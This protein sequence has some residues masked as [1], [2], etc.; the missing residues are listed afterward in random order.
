MRA[1]KRKYEEH[2]K[3][4]LMRRRDFLITR[5]GK[6][7]DVIQ[8]SARREQI[9]R[10]AQE[11]GGAA[12]RYLMTLLLVGGVITVVALAP[13]IFGAM[14][15]IARRKGFFGRKG[16]F[17]AK[18]YLRKRKYITV[19]KHDDAYEIKL[20]REGA[21]IVLQKSLNDMR[22]QP[23][24]AW[25]GIWHLVMFDIPNKH[26]WARDALR[27]RLQAMGLYRM[28]ESVFVSPYPCKEEVLFL[29]DLLSVHQYVRLVATKEIFGDT[30]L[31]DYFALG[32]RK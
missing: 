5:M 18:N 29:T 3:K 20:T 1:S 12:T 23:T 24:G 10:K 6:E 26:K 21:D 7:W 31:C 30:D 22:I 13:N 11:A 16:F 17:D 2:L 19:R 32:V 28:Q 4:Q 8:R 14:G 15:H 9:L 25:D 27:G